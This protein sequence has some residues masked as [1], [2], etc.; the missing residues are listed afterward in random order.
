MT[1]HEPGAEFVWADG[2][3]SFAD[4]KSIFKFSKNFK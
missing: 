4:P 2:R 3:N 1:A